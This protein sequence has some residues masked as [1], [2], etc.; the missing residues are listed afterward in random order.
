[1]TTEVASDVKPL[2]YR[3]QSSVYVDVAT[4]GTDE[5][6]GVSLQYA[7]HPSNVG[8]FIVRFAAHGDD[9]NPKNFKHLTYRDQSKYSTI[10]G[11]GEIQALIKG[12]RL[13]KLALKVFSPAP[14]PAL[15]QKLADDFNVW[16]LLAEWVAEQ[17]TTE[18]FTLYPVDLAAT[19]RESTPVPAL[20]VVPEGLTCVLD[21]PKLDAPEE[22]AHAL[23]LVG[24]KP[25]SDDE[26]EDD[27]DEDEKDEDDPEW[28][29]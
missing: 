2:R 16:T 14:H 20:P 29:N 4:R 7:I 8:C 5:F 6:L 11:E 21:L 1:M 15:I 17:A 9:V 25:V 3:G 13:N 22:Q 18:G 28:L 10:V 12:I 26:D 27:E 23:K 19:L 24:K